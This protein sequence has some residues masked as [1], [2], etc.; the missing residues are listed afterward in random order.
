MARSSLAAAAGPPGAAF[1]P[2]PETPLKP[3][4]ELS[5]AKVINLLVEEKLLPVER[6]QVLYSW[7]HSGFN[8]HAGERVPPEAKAD[9]EDP[10]TSCAIPPPWKR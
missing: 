2:L 8:L 9:L 3:L 7:K 10:S 4:E 5:R 6:V 1:L